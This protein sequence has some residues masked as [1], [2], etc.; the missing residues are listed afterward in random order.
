MI[1]RALCRL[2]LL[3][4]PVVAQGATQSVVLISLDGFRWDYIEKHQATNLADMAVKGVRAER[5]LPVY[6][7]KTFPN[8]LSLITGLL[9]VH[10][11]IVD[12][13]F[14]HKQRQECYKMGDGGKD[15]TWIQGIPLWN[16]A[17]MHG[18]KSAVYFWPESD[19]RI[20]GMTPSYYYHYAKQADYSNRVQQILDWLALPVAQRP[21]FI[22]GY[23]SLVDTIGHE[24]GPSAAQTRDAVQQVDKLIGLLRAGLADKPEVN[25]LVVADHGMAEIHADKA[26]DVRTLP[27]DDD[28][29]LVNSGTRLMYYAKPGV[30]AGQVQRFRQKLLDVANGRYQWLNNQRLSALSYQGHAGVADIILETQAPAFFVEKDLQGQQVMGAHGYIPNQ[31]M[32]AVFVAQGPAFKKG[33]R[34]PAFSNLDV[35][36]IVARILG[37]R[38]LGP[39]DGDGQGLEEALTGLVA[40]SP[41]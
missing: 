22:A 31:D 25:L 16:L 13:K 2:L 30:S 36:P 33:L 1:K 18:V 3:F 21:R 38:P 23:F 32:G 12:N 11:G 27:Y 7:S 41:H 4:C 8:H 35:Y 17:E 26:I 6:P 29:K 37:I 20:N 28:F 9:P 39:I 40:Q 5:M 10:H 19:A 24:F 15:S 14:C 34:I